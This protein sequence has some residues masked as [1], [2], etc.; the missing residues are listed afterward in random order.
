MLLRLFSD[1]PL[2]PPSSKAEMRDPSFRSTGSAIGGSMMTSPIFNVMYSL[3]FAMTSST[4]GAIGSDID[5]KTGT[6]ETDT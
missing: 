6:S 1:R 4:V 2:S 3:T 5:S